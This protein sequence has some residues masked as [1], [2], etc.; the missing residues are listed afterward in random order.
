MV[1]N[2]S[3]DL[4]QAGHHDT[5]NKVYSTTLTKNEKQNDQISTLEKDI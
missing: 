4:K 1:A 5:E 3:F 2:S